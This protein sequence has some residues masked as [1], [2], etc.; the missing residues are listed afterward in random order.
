MNLRLEKVAPILSTSRNHFSGRSE[1]VY[2]DRMIRR[3][4]GFDFRPIKNVPA[5]EALM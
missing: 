5:L 3:A 1:L 4:C 2:D